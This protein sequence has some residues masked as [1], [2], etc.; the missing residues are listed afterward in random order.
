VKDNIK[1]MSIF[2]DFFADLNIIGYS[3]NVDTNS[4]T[5][6][7]KDEIIL[8][9]FSP[10]GKDEFTIMSDPFNIDETLSLSELL[11]KLDEYRAKAYT[12]VDNVPRGI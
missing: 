7:Y 6:I 5:L 4:V 1:D 10:N 9:I 12:F 2:E 11:M 3:I 8:H